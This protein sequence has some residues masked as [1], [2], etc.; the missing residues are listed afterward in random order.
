[1]NDFNFLSCVVLLTSGSSFFSTILRALVSL[2][3]SSLAN[4]SCPVTSE[5]YCT[6]CFELTKI[7]IRT[8]E[9]EAEDRLP[10]EILVN[11]HINRNVFFMK[12]QCKSS[13][14]VLF[15]SH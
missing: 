1:M 7:G 4:E 2:M 15:K 9:S 8:E 12:M 5:E 6:V 14:M 3:Q 10:K 13:P 11:S